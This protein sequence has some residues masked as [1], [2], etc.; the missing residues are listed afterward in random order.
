MGE[1][2]DEEEQVAEEEEDIVVTEVYEEEDS[3][4]STTAYDE[5]DA[6]SWR[7]VSD[8]VGSDHDHMS[9]DG[10]EPVVSE[11]EVDDVD[12]AEEPEESDTSSNPSPV[13][14]RT[15]RTAVPRKVLTYNQLGDPVSEAIT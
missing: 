14:R 2:L 3:V 4:A 9:E 11:T 8:A 7:H 10:E 15:S 6:A 5:D 13:V 1:D 12:S